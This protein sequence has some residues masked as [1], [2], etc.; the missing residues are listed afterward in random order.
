LIHKPVAM[1][2]SRMGGCFCVLASL[3]SRSFYWHN[4][5]LSLYCLTPGCL[6]IRYFLFSPPSF[7]TNG[8][9]PFPLLGTDLLRDILLLPPLPQE[10]YARLRNLCVFACSPPTVLSCLLPWRSY[11][12]TFAG[13]EETDSLVFE[14]SFAS[15]SL[16]ALFFL[17]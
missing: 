4:P 10:F 7:P 8:P 6:I 12:L 13:P 17:F 11:L 1:F 2:D 15:L 5:F 16:S 9:L 14:F 3:I